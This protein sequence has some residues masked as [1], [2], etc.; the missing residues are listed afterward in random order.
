MIA[1]K[2]AF[3]DEPF[4]SIRW[5]GVHNQVLSEW[6]GSANSKELR[7]GLLRGIKVISDH[8]AVAYVSDARKVK[9]IVHDDQKWIKETWLP[10]AI[11]AGLRRIAW[12][13]APAGL[14]QATVEDVA[15]LVGDSGVRTGTFDSM[16]RAR[17]F[18]KEH[19]GVHHG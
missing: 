5:D 16:A 2:G 19:E 6:R 17:D 10:L 1:A 11:D 13:T 18:V 3:V 7:S 9:V 15:G 4:L 8:R 14:G 12:V